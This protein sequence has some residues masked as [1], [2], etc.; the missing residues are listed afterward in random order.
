MEKTTTELEG[1]YNILKQDVK[2]KIRLTPCAFGTGDDPQRYE[3]HG[4]FMDS[5]MFIKYAVINAP[6]GLDRSDIRKV[7]DSLNVVI[8]T[9]TK[10]DIY[11][12]YVEPYENPDLKIG[13]YKGF[14]NK[15]FDSFDG[16]GGVIA[17]NWWNC[18]PNPYKRNHIYLDNDEKF[19]P[20]AQTVADFTTFDLYT[21]IFH[22]TFHQLGAK[23][24]GIKGS[25]M[26]AYYGAYKGYLHEDDINFLN[27]NYDYN[28]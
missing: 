9:Q 7:Y 14:E 28:K 6:D 10:A 16:V 24:N 26:Y 18:F 8:K 13:A 19:A 23:H 22:E 15:P 2:V 11:F 12:K 25:L 3:T 27:D 20:H 21:T 1:G 4:C 5:H 17:Y